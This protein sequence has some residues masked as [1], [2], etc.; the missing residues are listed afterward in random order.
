MAA[1]TVRLPRGVAGNIALLE[2][3][4]HARSFTT[5]RV[6]TPVQEMTDGNAY[7]L[8]VWQPSPV[9]SRRGPPLRI[10]LT[11]EK[12]DVWAEK[13]APSIVLVRTLVD[14]LMW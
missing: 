5:D 6:W 13:E 12:I 8:Y 7:G 9:A 4:L 11:C 2:D 1:T 10:H 14:M 3:R